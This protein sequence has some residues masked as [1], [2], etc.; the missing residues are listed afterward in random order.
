MA[1]IIYFT[2]T[3]KNFPVKGWVGHQIPCT[4]PRP[5]G[6]GGGGILQ[7][8]LSGRRF[9]EH[10]TMMVDRSIWWPMAEADVGASDQCC[11]FSIMLWPSTAAAWSTRT[12]VSSQSA[13]KGQQ[14]NGGG[15]ECENDA[16]DSRPGWPATVTTGVKTTTLYE[17]NVH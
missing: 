17:Y 6:V 7:G 13:N 3:H 11:C 16:K 2:D 8:E 4:G 14:R 15:V 9:C 1:I 5:R 12:L 10:I